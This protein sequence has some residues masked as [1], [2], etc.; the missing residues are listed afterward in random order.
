MRKLSFLII[1]IP[2]LLF[3]APHKHIQVSITPTSATITAGATQQFAATVSGTPNGV[4]NWSA[5]AGTITNGLFTA[6]S[7]SQST[8]VYVR[9]TSA[10]DP[11]KT[12]TAAL[13]IDPSG[14]HIVNLNWNPSSSVN[15]TGYN[16]YRASIAGGPYAQINNGGLV[17]STIYT[18]SAVASGQ[19]YYYVVTAVDSSGIES[20]DSNETQAIVPSP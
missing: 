13:T 17:A 9:A 3:A 12:A 7:V 4:V 19:A 10:A 1:L 6:P 15:V 2:S 18:D 8:T 20:T 16:V 11:T 5:T 14:R